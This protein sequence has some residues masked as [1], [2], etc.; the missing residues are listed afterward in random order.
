M[1]A[2][3]VAVRRRLRLCHRLRIHHLYPLA[4]ESP[5]LSFL[6]SSVP[7]PPHPVP[8]KTGSR[9]RRM[10]NRR[11]RLC[12]S[13]EKSKSFPPSF[14]FRTAHWVPTTCSSPLMCSCLQTPKK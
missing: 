14:L 11:D 6:S 5:P 7:P 13:T 1:I 4:T 2:V 3:W 10:R 9:R 12:R 8:T